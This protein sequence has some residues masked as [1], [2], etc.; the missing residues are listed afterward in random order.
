MIAL[1]R[2]RSERYVSSGTKELIVEYDKVTNVTFVMI[3]DEVLHSILGEH[4]KEESLAEVDKIW[5]I[6][7]D[8]SD[9][10]MVSLKIDLV[11]CANNEEGAAVVAMNEIK[12]NPSTYL[13]RSCISNITKESNE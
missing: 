9:S 10:F 13:T 8:E 11:V 7:E 2:Y 5:L 3:G 6:V 4:S 12:K 1:N